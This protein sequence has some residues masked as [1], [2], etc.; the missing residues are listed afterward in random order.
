[1]QQQ[2]LDKL[3]GYA[4]GIWH[5]RWHALATTWVVS[6]LGWTLLTK[7]PDI[8][9]ARATVYVNTDSILRPLLRGLA[10]DI[11]VTEKLGLMTKKLL[12]KSNLER[13]VRTTGLDDGVTR[14]DEMNTIINDLSRNINLQEARSTRG[15]GRPQPPDLYI[16]SSRNSDPAMA[17]SVVEALLS[18]LVTDTLQNTRARSD[19]AQEFLDIQIAEYESRLEEAEN[20]LREFKR[21]NIDS[22]PEQGSSYFQRLQAARSQLEEVELQ[23]REASYRRNELQRQLSA[24]PAGQ[25]AFGVDGAPIQTATESRLLAL[26]QTLDELLL[27][28]TDSHPDVIE[29]KRSIRDLR[30]QLRAEQRAAVSGAASDSASAPN[31]VYQQLRLSLGEVEAEL[32]ALRVRRAEFRG[33]VEMLQQQVETLPEVEAELQR[34]NRNYETYRQ[35]YDTLVERRESARISEDVEQTGEDVKFQVIDPPRLPTQPIWPNRLVLTLAAFGAA[36]GAGVG[37]AFLLSQFR[38]AIYGRRAL[39][40][41]SGLPVFGAVSFVWSPRDR[42]RWRLQTVAFLFGAS[43]LMPALALAAYMQVSGTNIVELMNTVGALV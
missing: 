12:S 11:D 42:L 38:P 7:V 20:R 22:L 13:V 19:T 36:T 18:T 33:R 14:P 26:Q 1:M 23:I 34:L 30:E 35:Q 39:G 5:Y 17:A 32:A 10:I 16:I 3:L 25:R 41:V 40:S 8:Y 28:Y 37:L 43:L 2:Q 27:K 9:E 21:Q 4:R 15:T 24:T 6:L 29:T 31:P